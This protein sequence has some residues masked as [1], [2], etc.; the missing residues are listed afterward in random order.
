MDIR[1]GDTVSFLATYSKEANEEAERHLKTR[2]AYIEAGGGLAFSMDIH[3]LALTLR[4]MTGDPA[5]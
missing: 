4:F 5:P 2:K 3:T 1:D